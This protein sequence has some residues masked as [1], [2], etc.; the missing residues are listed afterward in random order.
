MRLIGL[1]ARRAAELP[2]YR[3]RAQ[4][5]HTPGYGADLEL[6]PQ[7]WLT[8]RA[9]D[10]PFDWI[11]EPVA[12]NDR[13]PYSGL[14][15]GATDS[16]AREQLRALVERTAAA[17][18]DLAEGEQRAL[19]ELRESLRGHDVSDL[20]AEADALDDLQSQL[21]R[22]EDPRARE[23]GE[24]LQRESGALSD[25]GYQQLAQ[26]Q[27]VLPRMAPLQRLTPF[28]QGALEGSPLGYRPAGSGA[29]RYENP[30]APGQQLPR[31]GI[32]P[33]FGGRLRSGAPEEFAPSYIPPE[34]LP[35]EA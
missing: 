30:Y 35:P 32:D 21:R 11:P 23:L 22:Y 8:G 2:R 24:S 18:L 25:V 17:G 14:E 20:E 7:A 4:L 1:L 9:G 16:A 31:Q 10:L 26:W 13:S 6:E 28:Q 15:Y 5:R 29:V 27:L 34:L 33:R 19:D 12:P 3:V